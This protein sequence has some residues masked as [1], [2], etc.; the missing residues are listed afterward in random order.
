MPVEADRGL[1]LQNR[2]PTR[3]RR[4]PLIFHSGSQGDTAAVKNQ[5]NNPSNITMTKEQPKAWALDDCFFFFPRASF[6][7]LTA[8]LPP[9]RWQPLG[10]F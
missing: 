1:E 3:D 7:F 8:L 10:D 4:L 2:T 5:I 9:P 6:I